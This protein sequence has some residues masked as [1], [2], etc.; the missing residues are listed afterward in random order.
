MDVSAQAE[1]MERVVARAGDLPTMPAVAQKVMQLVADEATTPA[2][3]QRVI[4]SDPALVSKILRVSNSALFSRVRAI[5]A[6]S[7]AILML[8]F[9]TI[10]SLVIAASVRSMFRSRTG[11]YGLKEQLLW[12]H[13]LG[14]GIAARLLA[15]HLGQEEQEAAFVGGLLHD[16]G[17]VVLN[18]NLA[19]VYADIFQEAYNEQRP[20]VA[21]EMERLGFTHVHVGALVVR[22]W[23]FSAELEDV[24]ANH[25]S[26]EQ[27]QLDPRGA[28]TIE[29]ADALC[30]FH[31]IGARRQEDLDPAGLPSAALLE[32]RARDLDQ[33]GA[34]LNQ[35]FQ[36]EKG[37][38]EG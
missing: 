31:G 13:S 11:E 1:D 20:I 37:A 15:R 23:N 30:R 25:H 10:R 2:D 7:Q 14:C 27:A 8:G 28:A 36:E 17:K 22:R 32:L 33:I 21:V 6:L 4:G 24:I 19:E 16:I 12:E 29:L 38:F 35:I 9:S 3:L 18:A 26:P 34:R 5:T